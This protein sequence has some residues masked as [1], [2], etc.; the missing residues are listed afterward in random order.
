M[1]VELEIPFQDKIFSHCDHRR[2][3]QS[4]T[5]IELLVAVAI[6]GI[7]AAILLPVLIGARAGSQAISCRNNLK[8]W[9]VA[10]H[11]Y[12]TDHDDFLPRNG[13]SGGDSIDQGW[14]VD[15]PKAMN[16][17]PYNEMPWRTNAAIDP[18]NSIWICPS[19]A[20]RSNGNNLFHYCLNE[21]ING[22]G[23]SNQVKITSIR[24]QA[25][26]VWLFDNGGLAP[27]AEQNNVHTNLHNHGAQFVFLD[28]HVAGFKN[29]AYW[30]FKTN[31]GITNNP[32]LVWFP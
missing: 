24:Q 3:S 12:A 2:F 11:L 16:L 30:N 28:A 27:V 4:F 19:N 23:S 13:S 1:S 18:G 22:T 8:Q 7:V 14:Y 31:K 15:L 10:T 21:N 6:I 5:L 25:T 17:P 9:G 26:A 29:T 32:D 20:R